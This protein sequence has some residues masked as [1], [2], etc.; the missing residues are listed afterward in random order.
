MTEIELDEDK[1]KS[2]MRLKPTIEHTASFFDCSEATIERFIRKNFDRT[3]T[4]FRDMQMNNTRH[5]LV[6]K[7]ISEGLGT[8]DKTGK[9]GKLIKG[10]PVNTAMLIFSLKNMAGWSDM[11]DITHTLKEDNLLFIDDEDPEGNEL[12]TPTKKN[13]SKAD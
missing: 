8:N 4:E 1:L 13:A 6:Q 5:A 2:F 9:D 12:A 7:A 3:F 11:K 10:R